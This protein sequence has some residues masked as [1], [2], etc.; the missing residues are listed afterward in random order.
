MMAQN[1]T[2]ITSG[3]FFRGRF[4]ENH[5]LQKIQSFVYF[6][7]YFKKISA[8]DKIPEMGIWSQLLKWWLN[9]LC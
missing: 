7:H 8:R 1:D 2:E 5:D 3:S 9:H 4:R 6:G